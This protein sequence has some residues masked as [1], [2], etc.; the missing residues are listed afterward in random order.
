MFT[1]G[2]TGGIGSGK[3]TVAGLLAARGAV[4][5]DADALARE[6]V[7]P[8]RPAFDAVVERFGDDVIGAD[9]ALDRAAVAALVFEDDTAR[10]D[11]EAITHPAIG[12]ALLERVAAAPADAVIVIDVPLLVEKGYRTYDLV[13]VVEAPREKRLERLEKRGVGRADAEA[14]MATQASDEQ[15]RAVAD[16]VI[17][18]SGD[19]ADLV[20]EVMRAWEAIRR[21]RS[22]RGSD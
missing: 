9:G 20:A 16:V 19:Q 13:L 11:L 1:V 5:V 6:V 4:V 8:G 3:S 2:L 12:E 10:A 14:R 18:N 21:T 17:D 7:E 22:E 15:R